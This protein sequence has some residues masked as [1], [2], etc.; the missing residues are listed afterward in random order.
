ME[1]TQA[2][3]INAFMSSI[4][5]TIVVSVLTSAAIL[6]LFY[7]IYNAVNKKAKQLKIRRIAKKGKDFSNYTLKTDSK[8]IPA[9]FV[10][11]DDPT[12]IIYI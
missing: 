2:D 8:G 9:L 11:I 10:N 5:S 12:D 7:C 6:F 1:S 4:A 3:A